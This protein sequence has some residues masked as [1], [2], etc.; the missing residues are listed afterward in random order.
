[1]YPNQANNI[2]RDGQ[3]LKTKHLILTFATPDL[4]QSVKVAYL[5]CPKLGVLFPHARQASELVMQLYQ[6][7][8][9]TLAIQTDEP[10]T[11]TSTH[12]HQ[13][14]NNRKKPNLIAT[15]GYQ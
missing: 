7:S 13:E 3:V 4:P 6:K 15:V 11:T 10:T 9:K 8:T 5:H 2:R 14:Q 12:L 1:M